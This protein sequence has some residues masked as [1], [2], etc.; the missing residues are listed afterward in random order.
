MTT[1]P[2]PDRRAQRIAWG[3][4]LGV[5]VIEGVTLLWMFQRILTSPARLAH[6]FLQPPAGYLAWGT[7]LVVTF[8][9]IA[10]SALRS[11][12]IGAYMLAPRRWL[13]FTGLRLVSLAEAAVTGIFEEV[14]F[15]RFVMDWALAQHWGAAAQIGLSAIVFGFAHGIWGIFGGSLRGAAGATL[16]TGALGAALGL[17]YILGGRNIAPCIASHAAVNLFLEP[18]L[19]LA[20]ATGSWG[21]SGRQTS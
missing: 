14:F 1:V 10:Y 4:L 19:I 7:T 9:Y 5:T 15:R 13:A 18:W 2:M 12:L 11:P 16:A 3:F 17:V 21:R 6:Y 8:L 20:A